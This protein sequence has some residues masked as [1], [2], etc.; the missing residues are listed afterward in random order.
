MLNN[1]GSGF[2]QFFTIHKHICGKL[3]RKINSVVCT[4]SC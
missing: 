2:S 4:Y 3:S 1:P